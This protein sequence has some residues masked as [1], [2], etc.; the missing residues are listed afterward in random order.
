MWKFGPSRARAVTV[1]AGAPAE[2]RDREVRLVHA[3]E[4]GHVDPVA[5]AEVEIESAHA[6]PRIVTSLEYAAEPPAWTRSPAASS[7]TES[8]LRTT[9]ES[10]AM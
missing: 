3:E 2:E 6:N 4:L 1:A 9:S 5:V 10:S 8:A 7:R